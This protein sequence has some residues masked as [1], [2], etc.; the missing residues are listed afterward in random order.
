M[1]MERLTILKL[2]G[3]EHLLD[4]CSELTRDLAIRIKIFGRSFE[5]SNALMLAL[6]SHRAFKE[7]LKRDL[8]AQKTVLDFASLFNGD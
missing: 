3:E 6:G 7:E 8:L 4:E 5:E 2:D 1:V